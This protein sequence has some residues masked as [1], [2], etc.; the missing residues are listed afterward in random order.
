VIIVKVLITAV[1]VAAAV[2]GSQPTVAYSRQA[3][4]A[5]SVAPLSPVLAPVG[6]GKAPK[7]PRLRQGAVGAHIRAH[8]TATI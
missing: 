8:V 4:V 5:P 3:P 2:W 6:K 1:A 7:L